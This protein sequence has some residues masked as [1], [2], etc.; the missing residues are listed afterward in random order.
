MQAAQA[1]GSSRPP[2]PGDLS[3]SSVSAPQLR[4]LLAT[5]PLN[6]PSKPIVTPDGIAVVMVCSREQKNAAEPSSD[7]TRMQLL[8][9]RVELASR[10]LLRGLR[11]KAML[12]D[13]S[14]S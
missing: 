5:L 12:D 11:R 7:E 13:R 6:Q 10:Q 2:N 3:L 14:S 4:E 8:E 1:A 9:Q